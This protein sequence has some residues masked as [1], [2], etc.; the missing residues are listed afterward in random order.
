[1]EDEVVPADGLV[2]DSYW[3]DAEG[4]SDGIKDGASDGM[5]EGASEGMLDGASEGIMEGASDGA[6]DGA[7]EGMVEGGATALKPSKYV[8]AGDACAAKSDGMG[9]N[10]NV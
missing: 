9:L 1:V 7:S 10:W 3:L 4:A 8:G 6:A 5:S 2:V